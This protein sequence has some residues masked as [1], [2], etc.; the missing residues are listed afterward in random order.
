MTWAPAAIGAI[1]MGTGKIAEKG[2]LPP[3]A[4]VNPM[5]LLELAR[6]K[7]KAAAGRGF[8]IAIEHIDKDGK[9]QEVNLF[10]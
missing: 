2:V 6:T 3:E 8:P 4:R 10:S 5:D 7:V 9:S 1:I